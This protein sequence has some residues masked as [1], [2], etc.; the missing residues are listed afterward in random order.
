MDK[1]KLKKTKLKLQEKSLQIL[2]Y[3][4]MAIKKKTYF[5]LPYRLG[6]VSPHEIDHRAGNL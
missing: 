1:S 4:N 6:Y 2:Q 3:G 5:Y